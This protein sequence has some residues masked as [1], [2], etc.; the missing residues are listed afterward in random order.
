MIYAIMLCLANVGCHMLGEPVYVY[1]FD[2]PAACLAKLPLMPV[3]RGKSVAADGRLYMN[4]AEW[5]E[6]DGEPTW[7]AVQSPATSSPEFK[8]EPYVLRHC[9]AGTGCEDASVIS[10]SKEACETAKKL[11]RQYDA[12]GSYECVK[13]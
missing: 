1:T 5:L 2:S 7:Q 3:A 9:V 13:Q 8:H 4:R 11:V 6:C 12:S 10:I